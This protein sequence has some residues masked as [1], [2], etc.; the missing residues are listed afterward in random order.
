MT[1]QDRELVARDGED[2]VVPVDMTAQSWLK[3]KREGASLSLSTD[4][5]MPGAMGS[6]PA[7][8]ASAT[9]RVPFRI[10]R[11]PRCAEHVK[12]K[13]RLPAKFYGGVEA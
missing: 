1:H 7:P 9:Q 6:P 3:Q 13:P 2:L 12:D 11:S 5:I 8:R 4:C 10:A